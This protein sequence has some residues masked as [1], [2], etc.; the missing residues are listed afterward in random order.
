MND[1]VDW[2]DDN[3]KADKRELKQK[4][5][6]LQ[7]KLLPYEE[8][9]N[10]RKDVNEFSKNIIHRINDVNDLGGFLSDKE[11]RKIMDEN[12]SLQDWMLD[13]PNA[14]KQDILERK[15][16]TEDNI[17]PIIDKAE[18]K[19]KVHEYITKN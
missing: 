10:A 8:K 17:K 5:Q 18:E 3:P 11:K 15:K 9:K 4:L 14:S 13:N 12:Q 19:K 2:V 16:E 1:L 7:E 6:Q